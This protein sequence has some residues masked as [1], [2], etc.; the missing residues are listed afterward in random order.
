MVSDTTA[1]TSASAQLMAPVTQ[2]APSSY[3]GARVPNFGRVKMQVSVNGGAPLTR[4]P[5]NRYDEWRSRTQLIQTGSLWP[6]GMT[7]RM[8]WRHA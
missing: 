1:H 7:F 6:D 8:F 4:V 2:A 3:A 5:R